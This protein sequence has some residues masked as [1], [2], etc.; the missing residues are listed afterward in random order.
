MCFWPKVRKVEE[1]QQE[2]DLN[3]KKLKEAEDNV[4]NA[5]RAF[6][7][8]QIALNSMQRQLNML[9]KMLK[10]KRA[11][12]DQLVQDLKKAQQLATTCNKK[13]AVSRKV[14]QALKKK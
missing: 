6:L 1:I 8:N 4:N 12:D 11:K 5:N 7:D 2:L 9:S 3:E 13:V 14:L 10:A